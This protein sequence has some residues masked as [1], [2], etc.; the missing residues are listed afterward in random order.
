MNIKQRNIN[1]S[2]ILITTDVGTAE[3]KIPENN[4]MLNQNLNAYKLSGKGWSDFNSKST[5]KVTNDFSGSI[6]IESDITYVDLNDT[7]YS[8]AI[9]IYTPEKWPCTFTVYIMGIP[10]YSHNGQS[11]NIYRPNGTLYPSSNWLQNGGLSA[12]NN[13][14]E[15][16]QP[17]FIELKISILNASTI[18]VRYDNRDIAGKG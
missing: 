7:K 18:L 5:E 9:N 16:N 3:G 2:D 10:N 12:G 6:F 11:I 1:L 13:T 17:T 14:Y 15:Y 4:G 8:N